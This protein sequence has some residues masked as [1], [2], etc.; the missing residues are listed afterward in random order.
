MLKK[1]FLALSLGVLF[2]GC[3]TQCVVPKPKDEVQGIN[4][5]VVNEIK[6]GINIY[7][8]RGST[9]VES[10]YIVYLDAAAK[11]LSQNPSYVL[12]LEGHTDSTGS[13]AANKRV[14]LN[15]ANAIRNKL[16]MEYNVNPAQVKAI[17]VGP[18]KPIDS[19][20]TEEGRSKNRRVS[21]ILKI[22]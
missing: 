15:R 12:E 20:A 6:N 22:Q 5:H 17:G 16:I 7:F 10:K 13:V 11:A 8:E 4:R 14:S 21:A 1:V 2:T 3:A 9:Q 18:D 19:N